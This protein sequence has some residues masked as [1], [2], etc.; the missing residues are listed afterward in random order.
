MVVVHGVL[1]AVVVVL[2]WGGDVVGGVYI[3][4]VVEDVCRGV[5]CEDVGDEGFGGHLD[6]LCFECLYLWERWFG[7]GIE[8]K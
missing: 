3:D 2:D 8:R 5:G 1:V 6:G 4:A 7:D